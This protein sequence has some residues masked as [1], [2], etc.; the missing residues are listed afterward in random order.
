MGDG[1]DLLDAPACN[2]NVDWKPRRNKPARP[3]R[4]PADLET[5]RPTQLY[6]SP[7]KKTRAA[8]LVQHKLAGGNRLDPNEHQ[9]AL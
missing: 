9:P 8:C 3:S 5:G 6:L 2:R 4:L 7:S 1:A